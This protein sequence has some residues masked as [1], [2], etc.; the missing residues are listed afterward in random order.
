M[1]KIKTEINVNWDDRNI[2]GNDVEVDYRQSRE[3]QNISELRRYMDNSLIID[4]DIIDSIIS[5]SIIKDKRDDVNYN[6]GK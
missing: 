3:Y 6:I 1:G 2:L 5:K 4:S